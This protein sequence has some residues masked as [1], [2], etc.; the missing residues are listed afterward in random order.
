MWIMFSI[1]PSSSEVSFSEGGFSTVVCSICVSLVLLFEVDF[2]MESL[3]I[4]IGSYGC[5]S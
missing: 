2:L 4:S 5:L 3:S 1:G